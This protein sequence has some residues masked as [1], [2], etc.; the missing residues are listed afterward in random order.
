MTHLTARTSHNDEIKK[1]FISYLTLQAA[2]ARGP[3]TEAQSAV[4]G[5]PQEAVGGAV[6][7]V[8]SRLRRLVAPPLCPG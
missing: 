8:A 5:Q 6:H 2:V 4:D 7:V 1:V 3:E